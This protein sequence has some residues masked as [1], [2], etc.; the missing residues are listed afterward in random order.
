MPPA[1]RLD[2]IGGDADVAVGAVFEANRC[3]NARGQF[4]V[5]LALSRAGTNR[6]PADQV[7][8]VLG[9]DHVQKLAG[10]GHAQ[11]VDVDEQ[12]AGDAQPFVDAVA[13]VQVGVV[14]Q[15]FPADGGAGLFKIHPHDDF[16]RV[17]VLLAHVGQAAGVVQ[18]GLGVVNGAGADDDQQAVILVAHDALDALPCAAD[19]GFDRGVLN[20]EEAD[21]VLGRGQHSNVLDTF[22][23]SLASFGGCAAVPSVTGRGVLS[24]HVCLC[25]KK[26][27][28]K[29]KKPPGFSAAAV[30]WEGCSWVCER[31]PLIR[32]G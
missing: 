27:I 29:N 10:C 14:D 30:V 7:S 2:G 17:F 19:Q 6:A 1:G 11:A 23:V 16:Q 25:V 28:V 4:A 20:G 12:L 15:A 24:G 22:V 9:R 18:R 13:A 8:D 3:R 21:E 26:G 31:L 32:Q 5:D